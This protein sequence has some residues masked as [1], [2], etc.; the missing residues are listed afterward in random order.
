MPARLNFLEKHRGAL[1]LVVVLAGCPPP[2][3]NTPTTGGDSSSGTTEDLTTGEPPTTV[4]TD[5]PTPTTGAEEEFDGVIAPATRTYRPLGGP[6][7]AAA[8]D[9]S[10]DYVEMAIVAVGQTYAA[11]YDEAEARLEFAGVPKAVY[12]LRTRLPPQAELPGAPGQQQ[13]TV[14]QARELGNYARI[15]AGR[16]DVAS[17]DDVSTALTASVG[18][19]LPLGPEDQFELYSY[20]AD[21]Q[22]LQ[23]PNLDP[24]DMSGSPQLGATEIGE[25]TIAWRP[26]TGR[27]GWPLVDPAEG[28]DLWLGHLVAGPLVPEP[29]GAELQDPWS[30]AQRYVLAEAA[31]LS[32]SPMTAGAATAA[33]GSFTKSPSEVV[34]L[35]V[36]AG[37]FMAELQIYDADLKSVGCFVAAVLEPGADHP[38]V[39]MTPNLGGINVYGLDAPVDPA[40]MGEDCETMFVTP[41]DRVLDLEFSNPYPVGTPTL[42]VQCSRYVFV[43]DP[44][45]GGVYDYLASDLSVQGRLE[46]LAQA[47]IVPKLG[48]VRDLAV[49]GVAVPP[50]S[51]LSG[52][53]VNPTISFTAPEFG[54]P[55]VYTITIRT[56]DDIDGA[57]GPILRR[58]LG[59]IRTEFTEVTI[60]DGFLEPGGH[61]YVQVAAERGRGVTEAHAD[62]HDIWVSRAM[63]GVL[64]P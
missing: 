63:T 55:D 46:D 8:H 12:Q 47:P 11:I 48:L 19:M 5:P 43:E 18:D 64:T 20:N 17:T 6:E 24:E 15:F 51:S 30:F 29:M 2:V 10:L 3:A 32:L 4:T 33:T 44:G 62:S 34:S 1:G 28:D 54:A 42:I 27:A 56:I 31:A 7:V 61:Y 50:D 41:G 9:P 45:G 22:L 59:S 38:I 53:G 39:G 37:E 36:R 26:D 25:W 16:P 23:F 49:N 21:A 35:D 60:P 13:V 58:S 14:S 52:V 57:D 40:C